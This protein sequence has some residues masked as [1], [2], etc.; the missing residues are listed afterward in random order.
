MINH[1]LHLVACLLGILG[2]GLCSL[3]NTFVSKVLYQEAVEWLDFTVLSETFIKNNFPNDL[4]F[5][6]SSLLAAVKHICPSNYRESF[7]FVTEPS[8]NRAPSSW[9]SPSISVP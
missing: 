3:R 4:N 5:G 8:E 2:L 9:M 1:A 6:K 7:V